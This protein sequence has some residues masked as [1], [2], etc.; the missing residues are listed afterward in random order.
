MFLGEALDIPFDTL[1]ERSREAQHRL[2]GVRLIHTNLKG[3]SLS[4]S[5]LVTMANERLDLIAS[6]EVKPSGIPG[7]LE[8]AHMLPPNPKGEIWEKR[9]YSDIGRVD[10]DFDEFVLELESEIERSYREFGGSEEKE[11][12]FLVGYSPSSKSEAEES[13]TEL[14]ELARS[15]EKV[16][17]D[18]VVQGKRK[19]DPRY[20]VGK[21]KLEEI[22]LRAKQ[23]GA[24]TL[25][26]DVE[27]SPAQVRAITDYTNL[28]VMDRTQLI[29]EIFS[30]RAKTSE[31][32]VQVQL[33]QLRYMLPRLT[34]KGIELSQL[35]GG[36]GTRGP[37]EKKLEEQRR[38]LRK[39][40]ETLE[41]QIDKIASRRERGRKHRKDTGI[42]TVTLIGYTS[43]GKS[44]LFNAITKSSVFTSKKLFSTLLPTTRKVVLPSGIEILLTDTVG[45]IRDL[46]KELVKAFRATLEELGESSMLLHVVDA[47]DPNVENNIESVENVLEA[48]GY[49][50]IKRVMVFNKVDKISEEKTQT[51][52]GIYD[53][54]HVCALDKDTFGELINILDSE[55]NFFYP[56]RQS[57][58]LHA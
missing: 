54:P 32:K 45:F 21:G 58:V 3:H 19:P 23:V 8:I 41:K 17:L 44:T 6:L 46:P 52:K 28:G 18:V 31:G 29:L 22:I 42:P 16:V 53:A 40:V 49:D 1:L 51:L 26:F 5:D 50:D 57:H 13:I 24:D 14:R 10:I 7:R 55:L 20:L 11:G 43:A 12:V 36:I 34:G 4:R 47:S 35:G 27:L 2:R 56:K 30:S 48:N 9:D 15:A 25:I 38:M 37:G 39:R 33:A